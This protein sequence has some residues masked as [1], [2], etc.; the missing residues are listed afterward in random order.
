MI[1]IAY[2]LTVLDNQPLIVK[3]TVDNPQGVSWR[4]AKKQLRSWYLEQASKLRGI[5]EQDYFREAA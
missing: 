2:E 3:T 4:E 5:S 1:R